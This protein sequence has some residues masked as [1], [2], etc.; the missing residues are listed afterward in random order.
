MNKEQRIGPPK[1]IGRRLERTVEQCSPKHL[2]ALPKYMNKEFKI[3]FG[4]KQ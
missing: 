1:L 2:T 3:T 4:A